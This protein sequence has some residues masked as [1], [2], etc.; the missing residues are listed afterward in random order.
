MN[1]ADKK[2]SNFT[3]L[4]SDKFERDYDKEPIVIKNYERFFVANLLP[5]CIFATVVIMLGLD[6]FWPEFDK[7]PRQILVN[8]IILEYFIVQGLLYIIIS[9]YVCVIK[10]KFEVKFTSNF[11]C[12]YKNDK[13]ER[14]LAS[15]DLNL[16]K[17]FWLMP[18]SR[19]I[20]IIFILMCILILCIGLWYFIVIPIA[21]NILFKLF[22]H[23]VFSGRLKGLSIFSAI[24]IN[25]LPQSDQQLQYSGY[26]TGLVAN[27]NYLLYIID[28]KA[29]MEVKEYFE[30]KSN[31]EMDKIK[32]YY[33]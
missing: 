32:K 31:I 20:E 25:G 15:C 30:Q 26:L 9:Y 14:K 3:N 10:N 28:K 13:I 11:I 6:Y 24:V 7:T 16:S 1:T 12:F 22:F 19:I 21:L 33:F 29:Y 5:F 4:G 27:K 17:S 23:I 18:S 2:D 8:N